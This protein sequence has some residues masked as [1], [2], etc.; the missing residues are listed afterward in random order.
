MNQTPSKSSNPGLSGVKLY[1]IALALIILWGSAFTIIS[2][3][4]TLMPPI[5]L[6]ALRCIVAAVFVTLYA[7]FRGHRLPKLTDTRWR[8]F[9]CLAITGIVIPFYFTAKGQETVSGG[10]SSILVGAMPLITIILA[11]FFANEPMTWRKAIGFLVGFGGIILLFL[12]NEFSFSLISNWRAQ[13]L[14][15]LAALFYAITTVGTKRA[16]ETPASLGA[17]MMTSSGALTAL[18]LALFS[19]LPDVPITAQGWTL[20]LAL[21][22]G[23]TAIGTILCLYVINEAGPTV[24]ARINY[25]PPVAAVFFGTMLLEEEFTLKIAAAFLIILTG[26]IISRTGKSDL[27]DAE[28][29]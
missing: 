24:L 18:I 17:A 27:A 28:K 26:V 9:F 3:G 14:L 4:V 16:P 7:Y 25:F 13:S 11:H 21:G 23:S 12:P 5:W 6:V 10:L 1:T 2:V 22:I 20:V 29:N 15:L 19:G 8:W